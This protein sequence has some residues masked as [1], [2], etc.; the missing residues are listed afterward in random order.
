MEP[1]DPR[2]LRYHRHLWRVLDRWQRVLLRELRR[3]RLQDRHP[4]PRARKSASRPQPRQLQQRRA[5]VERAR[6]LQLALTT[7]QLPQSRLQRRVRFLA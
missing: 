6:V 7:L 4:L 5:L 1:L 2:L 3:V